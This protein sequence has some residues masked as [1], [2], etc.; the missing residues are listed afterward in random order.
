MPELR[1]LLERVLLEKEEREVQAEICLDAFGP[2]RF[3]A[4]SLDAGGDGERLILL[5]LEQ[6]RPQA[7]PSP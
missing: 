1:G 5:G 4:R 6:R 2:V 7:D 3:Y